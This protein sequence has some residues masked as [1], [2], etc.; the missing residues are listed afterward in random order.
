VVRDMTDDDPAMRP[1]SKRPWTVKRIARELV[2]TALIIAVVVGLMSLWQRAEQRGEGGKLPVG[3]PAPEFSLTDMETGEVVSYGDLLGKPAVL[4]FW[5]T[6][7]GPCRAE[8]P[9]LAQIHADASGRYRL[10]T[11]TDEPATIVRPF[12]SHRS[13][14]LPV[15]YD[16][17][18]RVAQR[19]QVDSIPMTV[20]LDAQGNV[21]HDFVGSAYPDILAERLA[22]LSS[23]APADP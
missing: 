2:E 23:G 8:L 9:D 20:L 5:A 13:L 1:A 18:G 11:I 4:N 21:V 16:P 12:L 6:W 10:I 19:Y 22:S 17:G 15:L 3:Q 7:C 14:S